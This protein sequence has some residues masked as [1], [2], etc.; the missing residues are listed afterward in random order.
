[1]VQIRALAAQK[2]VVWF[3]SLPR[4]GKSRAR[5]CPRG[6][7]GLPGRRCA[8]TRDAAECRLPATGRRA[9]GLSVS[10]PA[11]TAGLSKSRVALSLW[12]D[13]CTRFQRA[14]APGL[15][16]WSV[17]ADRESREAV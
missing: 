15:R 10:A 11:P 5:R 4:D 2:A 8:G 12:Y 14:A 7:L 3:A 16:S 1:V 13:P 9:T 6:A 17:A